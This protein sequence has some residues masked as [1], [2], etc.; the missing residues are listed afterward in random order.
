[1]DLSPIP[2]TPGTATAYRYVSVSADT[3]SP[4]SSTPLCLTTIIM[5][6]VEQGEKQAET[7]S[8]RTHHTY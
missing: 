2:G 4:C 1:M 8:W 5:M 6:A 7:E 3:S